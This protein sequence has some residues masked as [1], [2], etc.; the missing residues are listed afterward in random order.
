M[1]A[2]KPARKAKIVL[3]VDDE[4]HICRLIKALLEPEGFAVLLASGG[5]EA[6]RILRKA[7]VDLVIVDFFMPRMS[8]RQ[9]VEAI[10]ED[11]ALRRLKVVYL[12]V[13]QF[14]AEGLQDASRLKVLDY[15]RKP[16]SND[17]LVR[18]VRKA[19]GK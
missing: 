13:A 4:E 11:D 1:A 19:V 8:G 2:K 7:E 6:L 9:L 14:G 16:F 17:D 10:R 12:P 15:I 5:K 3:I 18:R